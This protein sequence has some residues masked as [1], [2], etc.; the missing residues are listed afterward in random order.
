MDS[1]RNE[2]LWKEQQQQELL[3]SPVEQANMAYRDG[4]YPLLTE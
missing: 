1:D 3:E 4:V 2:D